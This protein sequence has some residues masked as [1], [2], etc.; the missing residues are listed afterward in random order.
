MGAYAF[1]DYRDGGT[2]DDDKLDPK[3]VVRKESEMLELSAVNSLESTAG[4]ATRSDFASRAVR[5][6]RRK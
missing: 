1:R 3:I 4:D 5:C 6:D 2:V